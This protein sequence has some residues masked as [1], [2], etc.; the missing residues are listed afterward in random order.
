MILTQNPSAAGSTLRRA[1]TLA[2]QWRLLLLFTAAVLAPAALLAWPFWHVLSAQLDH[3][4]YAAQWAQQLDGIAI[5]DLMSKLTENGDMISQAG[6]TA[7]VLTLLLSPLLTGAVVAAARAD[8]PL[9]FAKLLQG[10][11]REYG[12][13]GRMLLWTGV[14]LGVASAV[15]GAGMKMAEKYAEKAILEADATLAQR[16]AMLAMAL[17]VLLVLVTTDAGRAQLAVFKL[18]TSAIKAWWRG[19]K[20]LKSRPLALLGYYLAI[21]V[22]GLGAALA[23]TALRILLPQLGAFWFILG[24]LLAE[25]AVAL[26]A[27]MRI[28]RLLALIDLSRP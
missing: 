25:L 11:V 22:V 4:L 19:C 28:A 26:M 3:S 23:V 6:I 8:Q 20:L 13:M 18:R 12:R 15:G 2:L 1:A 14:L 17:L 16:A 24:V 7:A 9:G 27:W 21:T 5:P 10:G